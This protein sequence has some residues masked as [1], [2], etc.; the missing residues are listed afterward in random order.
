MIQDENY[1]E[2]IEKTAYLA[3]RVLIMEDEEIEAYLS[4][5]M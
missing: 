1:R 3:I 2:R 4:M 5:S